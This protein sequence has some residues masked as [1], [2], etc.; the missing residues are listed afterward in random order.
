MT[1]RLIDGKEIAAAL[2]EDIKREVAEFQEE[3][4]KAPGLSIIMVGDD[5]ASALYV[6]NKKRHCLAV[7]IRSEVHCFPK[8][9]VFEEVAA[10]IRD[11]NSRADIHGILIQLPVPN[12]LNSR[13]LLELVSPKKDVDGLHSQNVSALH[14]GEPLIIP[15][16]PL[17]VRHMLL[18]VVESLAGLHVTVV[19]RSHIVGRPLAALLL[20]ENCTVTHVHSRSEDWEDLAVRS[21]VIVMA[22]GVPDLLLESAV[23][24]GAIVID[25]G[26]T[27]V[28]NEEDVAIFVGDVDVKSVYPKA[29]YVSPV[30]GGVGPMTVA[31]LLKNT[32]DAAKNQEKK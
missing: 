13:D 12:H 18:T 16:T 28:M 22:A 24:A 30:P 2:R 8:D 4:G 10:K 26:S 32:L 21:D 19:G 11:L 7:G 14:T 5:P 23:K 17:G 20:Q 15:C 29:G 3:C 6:A 1:A 25:V 27:R 31:Y 9:V